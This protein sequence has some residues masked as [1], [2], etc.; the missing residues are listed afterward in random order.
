MKV[1]HLADTHLGYRRFS[2]LN[3]DRGLNQ[4]ECDI[5]DRWHEAVDKT[6]A[7]PPDLVIHAGD[8][9][10]SSRPAPR[11]VAEA[12]DGFKRLRDAGIPVVVIAGNHETPRFRSGGSVFE[13][14][15]RFGVE[16]VW[17][18]PRTIRFNGIAVHAVPHEPSAEQLANDV[19]SLPLDAKADANVLVLHAGLNELPRQG[20]N[21][22]N[23]IELDPEVLAEVDYDYIALGHLHRYQAP[24]INAVYPGSLE[25]LDFGDT[26][27]DKALL[28]VDLAI[29]AGRDRFV[30]R[31][32]LAARAVLSFPFDCEGLGPAEVLKQVEKQVS[33]A[34]LKD[35]V[36]MVR[37]DRIARDAYQALNFAGLNA[38]F[39]ECLHHLIHV[40]QGGLTL[41][42][43]RG[44]SDV[45][46]EEFARGRVPK[47]L[48]TEAVV[49][50]A[51][52]Y[53][54]DASAAE[55]EAEAG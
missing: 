20:Y 45:S 42:G 22:V 6:V 30:T 54:D 12:L 2:K 28:E 1:V 40:G 39:D 50:L 24:Q 13:I 26:D 8:L 32:P 16:A 3:G 36:V 18:A 43:S 29:G 10:D 48:D 44:G 35:A 49:A 41:D 47:G 25:R 27:G 37:L 9:F 5:Y 7:L 4:R 55:A 34:A 14:L 53:I 23:E 33:A 51:R 17:D 31:H 15:E 46:F 19:R 38:L 21:E 52:G 11:A